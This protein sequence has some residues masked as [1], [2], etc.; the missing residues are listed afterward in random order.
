LILIL[1]AEEET[2]GFDT[3]SE[4]SIHHVKRQESLYSR[5]SL[6]KLLSQINSSD[7]TESNAL[8]NYAMPPTSTLLVIAPEPTQAKVA[9]LLREFEARR[10]A[11]PAAT[12][13]P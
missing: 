11:P 9:Q 10:L 4:S 13:A 3:T 1:G 6:L 7:S 12:D 8:P 5:N 2:E